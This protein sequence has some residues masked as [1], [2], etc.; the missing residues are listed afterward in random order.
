MRDI[1]EDEP[2]TRSVSPTE[3]GS[4]IDAPVV[5]IEIA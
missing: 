3:F 4:G 5:G 1:G 2:M